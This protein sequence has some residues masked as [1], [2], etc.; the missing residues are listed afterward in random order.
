MMPYR[1]G[2][3]VSMN[4]CVSGYPLAIS[5]KVRNVSTDCGHSSVPKFTPS[6]SFIVHVDTLPEPS[7]TRFKK[8]SWMQMSSPHWVSRTSVS[9]PPAPI[10]KADW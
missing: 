5:R 7:D 9:T 10:S 3:L 6:R 8:R 2:C 4:K 1:E